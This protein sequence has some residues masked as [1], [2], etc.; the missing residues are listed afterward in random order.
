MILYLCLLLGAL[1]LYGGGLAV[2]RLFF[3][4]LRKFPGPRLAAATLWYEFYY[5]VCREGQL[6]WKIQEMHEEYG[7]IVRINPNELHIMDSD[8]YNDLYA[9]VGS[10]KRDKY[11]WWCNL[12]GAPGSIFATVGHDLHR[13]RRAPLNPFFSKRAV[14]ALEPLIREKVE[15]LS[16]RFSQARE[17]GQVIRLDCAFMALTM[18]V[19]CS[20]CFGTDRR[21]LASDDLGLEWKKTINGAWQKGAVMRQFPWIASVMRAFPRPLARRMD[22]NLSLLLEWQDS[23][24]AV[25]EPIVLRQDEQVPTEKEKGGPARS[26]IFH[27]LRDSDLPPEERSLKRLCDEGEIFTGA[28]SETTAKTLTTIMFYLAANPEPCDLLKIEL[29]AAMPD[30]MQL[31]PL[32]KL[33]QLPYLTAVI[34]EGLRLSYGLTTRLPRVAHE[35][36]QYHDWEIPPGTPVSE[37]PYF[38]LVD[39]KIFPDPETFR[40][41]RWL[42]DPVRLSRYQVC[43]GKGSRQCIGMN[44]A[45]AEL[46]LATA[47]IVRR[48]S[49]ELFDTT[50]DDIKIKHDFFAAAP[51]LPVRGVRA[52]VVG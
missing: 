31:Q 19:I 35:R 52:R 2:Y 15:T 1:L 43:F 28:G 29:A 30:P 7:P 17:T 36:L 40:P 41:E 16:S 27:T 46:Y 14:T 45:S 34:Q 44:L 33:E 39:P 37:T 24:R 6:I 20:Y 8:Y 23:V 49:L 5:D 38:I 42:N 10:K 48:F 22:R 26:T 3:H 51:A 25:V 32:T 4:P 12:A 47:V 18:D 21:Y 13:L 9:P 50:I 11:G